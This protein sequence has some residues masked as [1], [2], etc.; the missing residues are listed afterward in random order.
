MKRIFPLAAVLAVLL[1]L[2]SCGKK[3]HKFTVKNLTGAPISAIYIS[4]Q[5]KIAERKNYLTETLPDN[6]SVEINL[7]KLTEEDTA[8]GFFFDVY[9]AE[10][11]T[12]GDFSM[13]HVD[14]GSW[15]TFYLDDFGIAAAVGMTDEEVM[16]QKEKDH[17]DVFGAT[18]DTGKD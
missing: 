16:A 14:S 4:P 10:D 3:E 7:G 13:L 8:K 11:G 17:L 18:E 2:T 6:S 15:V 12:S 5:D 1:T 9:N